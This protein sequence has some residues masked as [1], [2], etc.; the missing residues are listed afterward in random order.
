MAWHQPVPRLRTN[1]NFSC[2][3]V[4]LHPDPGSLDGMNVA[5]MKAIFK[6]YLDET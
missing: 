4:I 6:G 1:Q 5:K 3:A 2:E